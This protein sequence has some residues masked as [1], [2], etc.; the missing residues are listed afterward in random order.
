M[1]PRG[2]RRAARHR[3]RP[4]RRAAAHLPRLARGAPALGACHAEWR[5][6]A[7]GNPH[8]VSP[9]IGRDRG[10]GRGATACCA[11]S[12][13]RATTSRVYA[14]RQRGRS[15]W[16]ANRIRSRGRPGCC[17]HGRQPQ[18]GERGAFAA[19][20]GAGWVC[21]LTFPRA[22]LDRGDA[23][24]ASAT[25]AA[26]APAPA[27]PAQSISGVTRRRRGQALGWECTS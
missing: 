1:S 7:F 25:G 9:V 12:T 22:R 17:P 26:R 24:P 4:A 15:S 6:R 23:P 8:P 10:G 16:W 3:V 20:R 13:P 21:R 19:A 18:L 11:G 27:F 14:E 2:A 5:R